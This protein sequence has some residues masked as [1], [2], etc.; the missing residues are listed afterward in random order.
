MIFNKVCN[1]CNLN[2]AASEYFNLDNSILLCHPC[3]EKIMENVHKARYGEFL[4]WENPIKVRTSYKKKTIPAKLKVQVHERYGYKCV[5]CGTHKDLTC[6]HI[7]P[8]SKG[9][10]TTLNNLQT[11]CR[12]CNSSKGVKYE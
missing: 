5:N 3:A 8:E 1:C 11:M 9:G 4:R 6:D 7:I 10:E 12:S 2:Y